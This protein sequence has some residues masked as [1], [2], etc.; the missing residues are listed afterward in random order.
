MGCEQGGRFATGAALERPEPNGEV[1]EVHSDRGQST[2]AGV[3]Y[4]VCGLHF[5]PTPRCPSHTASADLAHPPLS[6]RV[7]KLECGLR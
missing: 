7:M 6:V 5:I 4:T 3:R 2:T 1:W